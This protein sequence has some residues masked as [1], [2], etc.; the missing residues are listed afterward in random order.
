MKL[1]RSIRFR[2]SLML[3]LVFALVVLFGLFSLSRLADYH[4]VAAD[5]HDRHLVNTQFLGELNDLT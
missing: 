4:A 1:H 3:I 2:L 5:L